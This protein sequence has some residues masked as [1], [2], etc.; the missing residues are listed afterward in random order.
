MVDPGQGA[1]THVRIVV[2]HQRHHVQDHRDQAEC[3]QE[4]V[5]DELRRSRLP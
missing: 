3:G 2:E 4:P 5:E 1:E